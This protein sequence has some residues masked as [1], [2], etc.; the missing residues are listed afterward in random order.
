[1]KVFITHAFGGNDERFGSALKED[2]DAAGMEGYMAEK[3]QRYDLLISDKIRQEIDGSG[4]LVAIITKR[5]QSSPSVHEEIGYA[6]G[7]GVKVVLMVEKNV[8]ER[9]VLIYG[10][11]P[12]VF[13]P[14]E[15]GAHSQKI[16]EHING[17]PR[18]AP[19][20]V[21]MSDAANA[22]LARRNTLQ[23]ESDRFA[24][25]RHFDSLYNELFRGR[26]EK[27]VILF[28][29]CPNDLHDYHNV[30]TAEFIEWARRTLSLNVRGQPRNAAALQ[31]KIDMKSLCLARTTPHALPGSD[32]SMYWELQSNGFL[33]CGMSL[34]FIDRRYGNLSL[35]L[36]HMMGDFWT[37][38]THARLFYKKL[39]VRSPCTAQLSVKNSSKLTLGN[40]GNEALDPSWQY[41]QKLSFNAA[42]P[43]TGHANILINRTFG[44]AAGMTDADIEEAV[45]H[46]AQTLCNAYG[47]SRAKCYDENGDFA[48]QLWERSEP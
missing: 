30:G 13:D 20:R 48:W 39:G 1:M 19:E 24:Q 6:L 5:S 35:K 22:F 47:E 16:V 10:R 8:K 33:E 23:S 32:V 21:A 41:T 17:S 45:R 40:Y 14:Q 44:A 31:E 37:F 46:V 34:H 28:T 29:A 4:Y 9:G 18:T 3:S 36:S 12:E 7:R 25:N 43:R 2:L 15:F 42:D 11:E 26:G 38:L 27:P